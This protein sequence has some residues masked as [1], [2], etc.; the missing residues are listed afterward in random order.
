M[1]RIGKAFNLPTGIGHLGLCTISGKLTLEPNGEAEHL[2]A[3]YQYIY[4]TTNDP[5]NTGDW[6]HDEINDHIT[7]CSDGDL[8]NSVL[9][10]ETQ[11]AYDRSSSRKIVVSTDKSLGLALPSDN[12]IQKYVHNGG[13]NTVNVYYFLDT[14]TKTN[15]RYA[16][17]LDDNNRAVIKT[18][19]VSYTTDEVVNLLHAYREYAWK[20][21]ISLSDLNGWI[22]L[23]I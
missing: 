23:N 16:P 13:F 11:M 1:F 12:F 2:K 7:L 22:N 14:E 5:I 3:I 18:D 20:N 8:K 4:I 15:K 17:L 9:S 10:E 6:F 21:G 19:K